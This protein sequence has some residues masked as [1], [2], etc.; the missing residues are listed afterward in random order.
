MTTVNRVPTVVCNSLHDDDVIGY[1]QN[2][3]RFSSTKNDYDK[4][5]F[6][7]THTPLICQN[8]MVK[9]VTIDSAP[10]LNVEIPGCLFAD[11]VH[12]VKQNQ[13]QTMN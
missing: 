8:P 4:G 5:R 13:G 6:L 11:T 3:T 9:A 12:L 7:L 2:L 1:R 10:A